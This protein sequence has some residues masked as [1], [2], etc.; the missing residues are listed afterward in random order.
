MN[1]KPYIIFF[2]LLCIP[3]SVYFLRPDLV[4]NDSYGFLLFACTGNNAAG[5]TGLP[6]IVFSVLPC[7]VLLYK[8]LLFALTFLSG[9]FLI[10]LATLFSKKE[11]W[12]ACYLVFLAPM[13]VLDFVKLENDVFGYL[14]VFAS[15]FFFFKSLM[16]L[17][18]SRR[19]FFISILLVFV[20]SLFWS[21]AFFLLL[22][23][24]F[25]VWVLLLFSIPAVLIFSSDLIGVVFRDLRVMENAPF[26]F[27]YVW[28]LNFGILSI[29]YNKIIAPQAIFFFMLGV[30][31]AK[32]WMLS[33]PFLVVGLILILEQFRPPTWFKIDLHEFLAFISIIT[34]VMASQSIWFAPPQ[35]K[36]WQAIEYALQ[37]GNGKI[38]ND[39]GMGYWVLWK[40]GETE[41]FQSPQKAKEIE[42]GQV[43]VT[44][45]GV[46][47]PT[48]K[49]FEGIQVLKC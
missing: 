7:N 18:N 44:E 15:L 13:F 10:K 9:C 26:Q 45:L 5:V 48:I 30:I 12:R 40:G 34:L 20:G 28:L 14:F 43:Y 21:G 25:N 42:A 31:S 27:H 29:L 3:F 36:H 6:F 2:I 11:G 23:F 19:N 37:E 1:W 17:D 16:V 47:C 49:E 33:I 24:S 41:S 46:S 8:C 22:G 35:P 38:N 32:F 4:A 39:W